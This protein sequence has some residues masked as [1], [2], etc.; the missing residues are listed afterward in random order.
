MSV[1]PMLLQYSVNNTPF[2]DP[3]YVSELKLDGIR[4][5]VSN[6]NRVR[7]FSR[8]GIEM[9]SKY[10]ELLNP[11][12]ESGTELDGELIVTDENGK[13]DF[14]LCMSRFHSKSKSVPVTFV[15]FDIL[16]HKNI[17]V[18]GMS[19]MKR[20]ELLERVLQENEQ[21]KRIRIANGRAT[22]FFEVV[23]QNNLEGIVLKAKD[24][25][26]V[27]NTRSWSWQKVINW[28]RA[29]VFVTGYR[30]KEFGL[31]L[32]YQ[33][34]GQI[35]PVGVMELGIPR[36]LS[37]SVFPILHQNKIG[38]NKEFVFAT[39]TIQCQVKFRQWFRS[40]MMRSAVFEQLI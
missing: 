8:H 18:T 12:F 6:M 33:D 28:Q 26:Y 9:T 36:E 20:K 29:A 32:G 15:A 38:E 40:G 14:E 13:P 37:K 25:R 30:K 22:D 39:P 34:A 4:T 1:S 7:L 24:S 31:L 11:P 19:L 23:K 17:D 2:D 21:Y 27:K 3:R 16:T 10:P 35:R 5:I